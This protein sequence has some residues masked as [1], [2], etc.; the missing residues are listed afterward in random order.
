MT[1]RHGICR[2]CG[3]DIRLVGA[4][5]T[6]Q[7]RKVVSTTAVEIRSY[8]PARLRRNHQPIAVPEALADLSIAELEKWLD[9]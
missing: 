8:C 2:F 3:A 7:W 4:P 1:E 5:A 6:P 9:G